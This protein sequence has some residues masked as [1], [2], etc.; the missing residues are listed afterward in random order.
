MKLFFRILENSWISSA[1]ASFLKFVKY[2]LFCD[3]AVLFSASHA[4]TSSVIYDSP[5][6]HKNEIYLLNAVLMICS[7]LGTV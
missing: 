7:L 6:V 2:F 5:E 3:R 1:P 4:M